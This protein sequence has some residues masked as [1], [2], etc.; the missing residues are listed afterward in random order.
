M[1]NILPI[2]MLSASVHCGNSGMR[3]TESAHDPTDPSSVACLESDDAGA[4]EEV[5]LEGRESVFSASAEGA[6]N[7]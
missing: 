2:L 5:T 4:V 3:D 1:K 7:G 6:F